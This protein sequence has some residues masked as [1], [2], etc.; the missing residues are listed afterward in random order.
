M[1]KIE[2]ARKDTSRIESEILRIAAQR[3]RN[4]EDAA[5]RIMTLMMELPSAND[6]RRMIQELRPYFPLGQLMCMDACLRRGLVECVHLYGPFPPLRHTQI[7][8]ASDKA[9]EQIRDPERQIAIPKGERETR[10]K[11]LKEITIREADYAL[12]MRAGFI[13]ADAQRK[14]IEKVKALPHTEAPAPAEVYVQSCVKE[15][16]GVLLRFSDGRE[17]MLKS[18][19]CQRLRIALGGA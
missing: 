1:G 9:I 16:D 12:D 19:D 4:E 14:K 18:K 11:S 3:V 7:L 17:Y 6:R 2:K 8:D 15:Q 10:F 13:S 5:K